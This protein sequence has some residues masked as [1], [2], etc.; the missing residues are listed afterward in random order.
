AVDGTS[1]T[2]PAWAGFVA[3]VISPRVL[4]ARPTAVFSVAL[5]LQNLANALGVYVRAH[6]RDPFLIANLISS[7]TCAVLVWFL[8]K[9]YGVEGAAWAQLTAIVLTTLPFN[10]VLWRRFRQARSTA[11][12]GA[13]Q[14]PSVPTS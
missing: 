5:L 3:D 8:T 13:S 7:T 14:G 6:K 9:Q 1:R 10:Y 2:F 12:P 11:G 4:D